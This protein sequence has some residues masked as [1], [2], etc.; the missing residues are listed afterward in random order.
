M[1]LVWRCLGRPPC[2]TSII[3]LSNFS[4][5]KLCIR[6]SRYFL[7]RRKIVSF[8]REIRQPLQLQLNELYQKTR[9]GLLRRG[10]ICAVL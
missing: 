6:M 4:L 7:G 9:I 10:N 2:N 8:R 1:R 3:F 5:V